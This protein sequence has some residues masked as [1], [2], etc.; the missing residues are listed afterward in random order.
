MIS[1]MQRL[2]RCVVSQKKT[3]QRVLGLM[4]VE[5]MLYSTPLEA[6]Q[7]QLRCRDIAI[8]SGIG[9]ITSRSG[10]DS[11]TFVIH[12]RDTH[13]NSSAQRNVAR[14]LQYLNREYGIDTIGTEGATGVVD[15]AEFAHFPDESARRTVAEYFLEDGKIDGAEFL[16]IVEGDDTQHS[17]FSLNGIEVDT[18]YRSNLNAF[19]RS[20]RYKNSMQDFCDT[21]Q[22]NCRILKKAIYDVRLSHFDAQSYA[23]HN[24]ELDF[25]EYCLTLHRMADELLVE[26]DRLTQLN[27]LYRTIEL[28]QTLDYT[29][30]DEQR[31]ELVELLIAR[32]PEKEAAAVRETEL[33]YHADAIPSELYYTTLC[34]QLE[35]AG[36]SL[37][38]APDFAQYVEYL[39]SYE[40]LNHTAILEEALVL[41]RTIFDA[42]LTSQRQR[43]LYEIDRYV[44]LINRFIRLA[45]TP[46]A[47]DE[48]HRLRRQFT[49]EDVIHHVRLMQRDTGCSVFLNFQAD[50]LEANIDNFETFYE[51]AR[52]RENAMVANV[53]DLQSHKKKK[54]VV[55]I[56][57][58]FHSDG[59]ESILA[60][61]GISYLV[62]TPYMS[63][64]SSS[65]PYLSLL[66]N[67]QTPL[68]QIIANQVSTLKVATWMTPD[69]LMYP[70]R[71]VVLSTKMK[72]LLSTVKL[73]EL[74]RASIAGLSV[75]EQR[76]RRA[77]HEAH[78]GTA[79]MNTITLAGYDDVLSIDNI[80]ISND[81]ISAT[82]QFVDMAMPLYVAFDDYDSTAQPD[83]SVQDSFLEML[84]LDDG[85]TVRVMTSESYDTALRP[86]QVTYLL[87]LSLL[88]N[89]S[90]SMD[91]LIRNAAFLSLPVEMSEKYIMLAMS[92]LE[93]MGLLRIINNVVS[94]AD[95]ASA[96]LVAALAHKMLK[97]GS[98]T[99]ALTA[100]DS[101]E[102]P[103]QYRSIL[104]RF[105][106]DNILLEPDL[107]VNDL[108]VIA[109]VLLFTPDS[110][111]FAPGT[112]QMLSDTLRLDVRKP[113]D[114]DALMLH[115]SP[116]AIDV[117]Q[118]GGVET[119][120]LSNAAGAGIDLID[121]YGIAGDFASHEPDSEQVSDSDEFDLRSYSSES[122]KGNQTEPL[123]VTVLYEK[124][125]VKISQGNKPQ[126]ILQALSLLAK[127][128]SDFAAWLT[129]SAA[130][131]VTD[132]DFITRTGNSVEEIQHVS[133]VQKK[134]V[135]EKAVL[136]SASA[137]YE[138][139]QQAAVHLVAASIAVSG[140]AVIGQSRFNVATATSQ[141]IEE[142]FIDCLTDHHTARLG[143]EAELSDAERKRIRVSARSFAQ[144]L[145]L[146]KHSGAQLDD[147]ALRAILPSDMYNVI[148]PHV[149]NDSISDSEIIDQAQYMAHTLLGDEFEY[150]HKNLSAGYESSS[151]P[152]HDDTPNERKTVVH[153][154][155]NDAFHSE[156]SEPV[157]D[158]IVA[159]G[160]EQIDTESH[161]ISPQ[162]EAGVVKKLDKLRYGFR[163]SLQ[164]I[165]DKPGLQ[166]VKPLFMD[167]VGFLP[168]SEIV[169]NM[170]QS[171]SYYP[172][173]EYAT[174]CK[175][176]DYPSIS[177]DLMNGLTVALDVLKVSKY[178]QQISE[179]SLTVFPSL[180]ETLRRPKF[181]LNV[182]GN[183]KT[184]Y[185][186]A[187][188]LLYLARNQS[189]SKDPA[190]IH[191]L[192]DHQFRQ[193][194]RTEMSRQGVEK[195][196]DT[197]LIQALFGDSSNTWLY[198]WISHIRWEQD[199][200]GYGRD[201]IGH[202]DTVVHDGQP[203]QAED[204][205]ELYARI[206]NYF[207][208]ESITTRAVAVVSENA[209][210]A[211]ID[212][213][214]SERNDPTSAQMYYTEISEPNVL[215]L[216]KKNTPECIDAYNHVARVD[217]LSTYIGRRIGLP[218][219][220]LEILHDAALVHALGMTDIEVNTVQA[221][222]TRLRK[223]N[224]RIFDP[225]EQVLATF[226]TIL[227]RERATLS[228]K[229]FERHK[230][231]FERYKG[232]VR[233]LH[234]HPLH[235]LEIIKNEGIRLDET[236]PVG[237]V[238][239]HLN[240]S[241]LSSL[242]PN[243]R[244]I[245]EIVIAANIMDITQDCTR[246]YFYRRTRPSLMDKRHG[247]LSQLQWAA[248]IGRIN[249][250]LCTLVI[251]MIFVDKE[252][253]IL[254]QLA[255]AR[256]GLHPDEQFEIS[257]LHE[258][259]DEIARY[260]D[261]KLKRKVVPV[262]L[263]PLQPVPLS[264]PNITV[265]ESQ[266]V[267]PDTPFI[268][269]EQSERLFSDQIQ[270]PYSE[271]SSDDV[272][273]DAALQRTSD[274]VMWVFPP[275][276][277]DRI[278]EVFRHFSPVRPVP[279]SALLYYAEDHP[280]AVPNMEYIMQ[281]S[282]FKS[283]HSVAQSPR[284]LL[285]R[286]MELTRTAGF[287]MSQVARLHALLERSGFAKAID[288]SRDVI[289]LD[290]DN[291]C[292]NPHTPAANEMQRAT[293]LQ[294][295][296]GL[297][298]KYSEHERTAHIVF[299][300][301]SMSSTDLKRVLG[302]QLLRYADVCGTDML[303]ELVSN[304]DE[305]FFS[306]L[307]TLVSNYDV[308]RVNLKVFSNAPDIMDA[309]QRIG[310]LMAD[311]NGNI[312][313]AVR[314]FANVH[315]QQSADLYIK[316]DSITIGALIRSSQRGYAAL[317]G[318]EMMIR[319][320]T[321]SL[322]PNLRIRQL[323]DSAA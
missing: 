72:M 278:N 284:L 298:S 44:L 268:Q 2:V 98:D 102:L 109:T 49:I 302:P 94:V 143:T 294:Y 299:F 198:G 165:T 265:S 174:M 259:N 36:I 136:E 115:F 288:A 200:T 16:C 56:A 219:D 161:Q 29:Q 15:V 152:V 304:T 67:N 205:E 247:L 118:T 277:A 63:E 128:D 8:P 320:V 13:A 256:E 42:L 236:S 139:Q 319:H 74:Y 226:D 86:S 250:Q 214:Y 295:V 153:A 131:A 177:A 87:L 189:Q 257:V 220:A 151:K 279:M 306:F 27:T 112:T 264:T 166:I 183:R 248:H 217:A 253:A 292:F 108:H 199:I 210:G 125:V 154:A 45:I 37:L 301:K 141:Q 309:A 224:V 228:A 280:E 17:V 113:I 216:Y 31:T 79:I 172:K 4:L 88:V 266:T 213:R 22:R 70:E 180:N 303:H 316:H 38:S 273:S 312:F 322:S 78:L 286:L 32:L 62:I 51:L 315:P 274:A 66:S 91:D 57:G 77:E 231:R 194:V 314:M 187:Q 245:A 133:R 179:F 223:E 185:I 163:L 311:R 116:S 85:T 121:T 9:Q 93:S 234:N 114:S 162:D 60:E 137:R 186:D 54:V 291:L 75:A 323:Q 90:L 132:S 281:N 150:V 201:D 178:A 117:A 170:T 106:I 173:K 182:Q 80:V 272:S 241:N 23:F 239:A 218:D 321:P 156:Q 251:Q 184:L 158:R 193:W 271:D 188:T 68:E 222:I 19:L 33:K 110:I 244:R 11:D 204:V 196:L 208:A 285:D 317:S 52:E 164:D 135:I 270:Q 144:L 58:G 12:I 26:T 267:L 197:P 14:I 55:M 129:H 64:R 207:S 46:R 206:K 124:G 221:V 307:M 81:G 24:G 18:L 229:K 146:R 126:L 138:Q 230:V 176:L 103:L 83:K 243:L 40:S 313:D 155:K 130:I 101:A 318:I 145:K 89:K 240:K 76:A 261:E 289:V 50:L 7:D 61:K 69:P 160:H 293:L 122:A 95:D 252:H 242:E 296:K 275:V 119:A 82:V 249:P 53:L 159:A 195:S 120:Q 262:A 105:N 142:F 190:I 97:N 276:E 258:M 127:L 209:A 92:D 157:D 237:I 192:F 254:E 10:I 310:A 308:S 305:P 100:I 255:R 59:I 21:M 35:D 147:D 1:I 84:Q 39:Q 25:V 73:H 263:E 43:T 3:L 30:I 65:I 28:E 290:S 260:R 233:Q 283:L 287:S 232:V 148:A 48:Y 41:E 34:R 297:H 96:L 107:T 104:A 269:S 71:R 246:D 191:A 123:S 282:Y 300:S 149:A 20:L 169:R 215:P 167:Q 211:A 171:F 6:A 225:I 5:A 235:A 202:V 175:I 203:I 111:G 168:S 181:T 212:S 47:M 140:I 238:L 227:E 99:H 134:V